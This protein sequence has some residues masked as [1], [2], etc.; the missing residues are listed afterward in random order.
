LQARDGVIQL[1]L[2]QHQ[3]TLFNDQ[4]R[5]RMAQCF[6][7]HWGEHWS[8]EIAVGAVTCETPAKYRERCQ[9]ERLQQAQQ[10]IADD[11]NIKALIDIFDAK[12]EPNSIVPNG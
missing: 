6:I 1:L 12:L 4:Q 3:A 10:A 2:D 5:E 8:L 11:P 7:D 9:V